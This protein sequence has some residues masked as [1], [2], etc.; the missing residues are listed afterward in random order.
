[1]ENIRHNVIENISDEQRQG[2]AVEGYIWG[3]PTEALLAH[4]PSIPDPPKFDLV[5]LSDLIFNHSQV[6]SRFTTN[7]MSYFFGYSTKRCSSPART[8]CPK[9]SKEPTLVLS[10]SSRIIGHSL[11]RGTL[12]F[13]TLRRSVVGHVRMCSLESFRYAAFSTS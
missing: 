8:S 9:G 11:R 12:A 2:V 7:S 3:R 5:I 4:L 10:Y 13:S 1:M 6:G